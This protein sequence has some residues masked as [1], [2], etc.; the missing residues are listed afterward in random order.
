MRKKQKKQKKQKEN[1]FLQFAGEKKSLK[2]IIIS[3]TIKIVT[4]VLIINIMIIIAL[5]TTQAYD[6]M[7]SKAADF[8]LQM[9]ITWDYIQDNQDLINYTSDGIYD[10]KGFHCA[11]VG[12][13]L[14]TDISK[15]TDYTLRY[16]TE[17]ARSNM[18][19][20]NRFE[21]EALEL[22]RSDET[23]EEDVFLRYYEGNFSLIYV[24]P[25]YIE[26]SCLE[27][28]GEPA[29]EIDV[30]GYEKEGLQLGDI[31]GASSV[32]IPILPYAMDVLQNVL[33]EVFV[34]IILIFSIVYILFR[35]VK[36]YITN[37]L[38]ELEKEVSKIHNGD[39]NIDLNKMSKDGELGA[40]AN[41]I[42]SMAQQLDTLYTDLEGQVNI[43]TEELAIANASLKELNLCL[44]QDSNYKSEF[45]ALMSHELKTPLAAIIAFTEILIEEDM[46]DEKQEIILSQIQSSSNILN[47]LI[48][49][50]LEMARI[51]AGKVTM[52]EEIVDWGDLAGYVENILKPLAEK[53]N[54]DFQMYVGESI[55]VSM[56]DFEKLRRMIENIVSNAIK[57]TDNGGEIKF[58]LIY[59]KETK[60]IEIYVQDNGIGIGK[61]DL[62]H[63]FDKFYQADSSNKRISGGSG[64]G[65]SL[66]ENICALHGGNIEVLS[67]LGEGSRFIITLPAKSYNYDKELN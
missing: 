28:H 35:I 62:K 19:I 2:D 20:A 13:D 36:Y 18:N 54:I 24:T 67:N 59:K 17:D 58:S 37:P 8:L 1:I 53:K 39:F 41:Q 7:K 14:A 15:Y 43:R 49:N 52:L 26:E 10:Y 60:D 61:E 22:F 3:P 48:N 30:S 16:V 65:L 11:I 21:R 63:I 45:L 4:A 31:Y 12:V 25:I 6:E 27:C 23:A 46:S 42:S 47:N 34:F 9:D 64:L 5:T 66:V 55:P 40:L 38:S 51:E 29:G 57:F 50:I 56:G 32:A 33:L 44:Q